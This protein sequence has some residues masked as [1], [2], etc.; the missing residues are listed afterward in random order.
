[1]EQVAAAAGVS[2]QRMRALMPRRV[3]ALLDARG[4]SSS[5][6]SSKLAAAGPAATAAGLGKRGAGQQHQQQR[7]RQRRLQIPQ[8]DGNGDDDGYDEEDGE[9]LLD[10]EVRCALCWLP[11]LY[12]SATIPGAQQNGA[13][14]LHVLS[15]TINTAYAQPLCCCKNP[16]H[17]ML[18]QS[19]LPSQLLSSSACC[20]CLCCRPAV[21][22]E[23]RGEGLQQQT[24]KQQ[25][26]A[27]TVSLIRLRLVLITFT[28]A[29]CCHLRLC[30][31]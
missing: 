31:S 19:G 13:E 16:W 8:V 11:F 14:G 21:E 6:S 5:S 4:R 18:Q 26:R 3:L 9:W 10:D 23:D 28:P 20:V 7:Q 15:G 22:E 30:C 17:Y 12:V 24:A 25:M 29:C 2:E 27:L 1:V